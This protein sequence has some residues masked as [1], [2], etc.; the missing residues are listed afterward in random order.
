MQ[1]RRFIIF[2]SALVF[3]M[4]LLLRANFPAQAGDAIVGTGTP[5]S[6]S[7][8]AFNTALGVVQASGGGEITFNCGG[9]ASITFTG[10][11]TITA[12]VT[13]TGDGLITLSGAGATR[14]FWVNPGKSLALNTITIADGNAGA[15]Y[16]GC[17]YVN[18][19]TLTASGA[20]FANC[21]TDGYDGGAIVAPDSSITLRD[22]LVVD[23]RAS[24]GALSVTGSLKLIRTTLQGNRATIGGAAISTGAV[25]LIEDSLIQDNEAPFGAGMYITGAGNVTVQGSRFIGNRAA[26]SPLVETFGGAVMNDG[27]LYVER[28]TFQ[29][30]SASYF[31]GALY[32]GLY[33]NDATT[34]ILQSTFSGNTAGRYGGAI[35]NNGGSLSLINSTLSGNSAAL[36]G[37]GLENFL[38]PV[39]LYHVTLSGNDGG[40]LEQR[41]SP[42]PATNARQRIS[43]N[44]SVLQGLDGDPNCQ[45]RGTAGPLPHF[46]SWNF[47][48]ADDTACA[49]W[50]N[51]ASD[52]NATDP[53]LGSLADNGG[54]TFTHLP[55]PAGALLDSIPCS[56][57]F[58]IDQRGVSRP[59]GASCEPGS[60]EYT[61]A[62]P[63]PTPLPSPTATPQPTPRP[64]AT[65]P[66]PG[67]Q[68]PALAPIR[69]GGQRPTIQVSPARAY[70]GQS[71]R[72][73]G[74]GVPGASQVRISSVQNGRTVGA[75]VANV[76]AGGYQVDL[77]V[78]KNL[79]SGA[80]QL[81]ASAV[82][83][84]NG[85]LACTGFTIDPQ[86]AGGLSGQLN[87]ANPSLWNAQLTLLDSRGRLVG[88]APINAAGQFSLNNLPPGAY[89][90]AVSGQSPDPVPPGNLTIAG[91]AISGLQLAPGVDICLFNE[92]TY[93]ARK[94]ALLVLDR[95]QPGVPPGEADAYAERLAA[96]VERWS[97]GGV[98]VDL[99][100]QT[101]QRD[102]FGW[103]IS[104]AARNEAFIAYPQTDGA[105]Q[106]VRFKQFNADGV[107]VGTTLVETQPPYTAAL[108]MGLFQPSS[109]LGDPYIQVI[110]V[111]GGKEQ[112]PA[113][114]PV[115]VMAD[116]M[117]DPRFRPADRRTWW[118]A[119]AG[120]YRFQGVIPQIDGI[121]VAFDLPP[122]PVPELPWYKRF[123]NRLDAGIFIN[124]YL[125]EDG[126][127]R[128][129]AVNAR[130][131]LV[132]L[133]LALIDPYNLKVISLPESHYSLDQLKAI[134]FKIP[135]SGAYPV[136]PKQELGI[137]FV[138][139]PVLSLFGLIDLTVGSSAKASFE[140]NL[141]G[142]VAPF[143]P[144]A[145]LVLTPKA[146]GQGELTVGLR[147]LSGVADAGAG[148]GFGVDVEMPLTASVLPEPSLTL[149]FCPALRVFV[150]AY[151]QVL[152][153]LI[154]GTRYDQYQD[155]T[156]LTGC[157]NIFANDPPM[158]SDPPPGLFAAPSLAAG[159]DGRLLAA[160]VENS[161]A[162]G[163]TP[164]VQIMAR[165][166]PSG[167]AWGAVQ[168]VS[169]PQH[170]AS[171]P[172][173]AFAGGQP[174]LAWVEK[175]YD[176][177]IAAALGDDFN[178]HLNRQEIFYSLQRSSAWETPVRLTHDLAADGLP[179][180]AGGPDGAVLAWTRDTDGNARTRSDQRIA[181]SLFDP[182][183]EQFGAFD[184]LGVGGG[185]LNNDVRAAYDLDRSNPYLVW[186]YDADGDLRS[187]QDRRIAVGWRQNG[188]WQ[189]QV[190]DAIPA[191][192]DSPAVSAR[193]GVV[194][195][196]FLV[197]D[198]AITGT[199][200]LL[201]DNGALWTAQ[202]SG[203][204]WS[205]APLR[206]EDGAPVYAE[207]PLLAENA[208]EMLLVFRR[209]GPFETN[210]GLGQIS[211]SRQRADGGFAPP[212]YLTD[213]SRQNWQP[214][215]AVNPLTR[216]LVILKVARQSG[217][218]LK[219]NRLRAPIS[220]SQP[221]PAVETVRLSPES[222]A[223][224]LALDGAAS[225]D[226]VEAVSLGM[227]ADPAL[228]PL[229]TDLPSAPVGQ[230]LVVWAALRNLGRDPAG[231][232]QVS[233]YAGQPGSG[234]LLDSRTVN[235]P[236]DFNQ[237]VPV[238][239][240]VTA[241]PGVQPLY[242]ALATGGGNLSTANDQTAV[243][244]LGR[245]SA[246][247]MLDVLPSGFTPDALD[248]SW[249]PALDENASSY[250]VLRGAAP[251]GPFE[252]IGETQSAVFT[253]V[254]AQRGVIYCYAVQAYN[255]GGN[256]SPQSEALCGSL[257]LYAVYLPVMLKK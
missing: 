101:F 221:R 38:G 135:P 149:D 253:D 55:L 178:A 112:C 56:L 164:Q 254:L 35:F 43:L 223:G 217:Q 59:Q 176:A 237:S 145:A 51:Q 238:S 30:N 190:P 183:L 150:H 197:R 27:D 102:K 247:A 160:Y 87:A 31:G 141:R 74:T 71:V 105:V 138:V 7:E 121:P 184:L 85:E 158:P 222:P 211:L 128:I 1:N 52:R 255:G 234:A 153:G 100:P 235:G 109:S 156:R 240:T 201:G 103:Y 45:V 80:T 191:G 97:Q 89:R 148:A 95:Q 115:R 174:L 192:A 65:V 185:G 47:N 116:P 228:D 2:L 91:G 180:I 63:P 166:Q 122:A 123:K 167:G 165:F 224:T 136:L 50:L 98:G 58:T 230:P 144:A 39:S 34:T 6:C 248:V 4:A 26:S 137:P 70:G 143:K 170:S 171:N 142:E 227:A 215:L 139:S 209:F 62:V 16:G 155:I 13:I 130:A 44:R 133:N 186:T 72:I 111:V 257:P 114:F 108:N 163:A 8:A 226:P 159:A 84:A 256:L 189:V 20:T 53:G 127:I 152:W 243:L 154:P 242:A 187:G 67:Y 46:V 225:L 76:T 10:M 134:K 60:V 233:L 195:L 106:Q 239:F 151:A 182:G 15:A 119:P 203:G 73:S 214:A 218:A 64:T 94:T 129:N 9:A 241:A 57:D 168:A 213:E 82:G 86:P 124:G 54:D 5:A 61:A 99:N 83:A 236:L 210:A 113:N 104:G 17:I 231:T 188:A 161:A 206:D 14:L 140:A 36:G 96:R 42:D 251:G 22:S 68:P 249:Y 212:L 198:P 246:P 132:V 69:A 24:A 29:G 194:T 110:P 219:A 33:Q 172:A 181:V 220:A 93:N 12:N 162:A 92:V 41:S 90:Y 107:Q 250:R 200:G 205:A 11:K 244:T 32:T 131:E 147:L 118:D 79:R 48:L 125:T 75:V 117:N 199:L 37:G 179:A 3:L 21:V 169:D 173:A 77:V 196:A 204:V 252:V 18:T 81:C 202:L 232:V 40:S 66:P 208:G 177:A 175:P 88:S 157:F 49:A 216:Q 146:A 126:L 19:A 245:L 78:P 193:D 23:N 229:A 120:V 207:Q 25:T 28:S